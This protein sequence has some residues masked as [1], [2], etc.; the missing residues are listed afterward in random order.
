MV[1]AI[2]PDAKIE[3][4]GIRPGEKIHETLIATEEARHTV[5]LR[6]RYVILPENPSWGPKG[7]LLGDPVP[8][9]GGAALPGVSGQQLLVAS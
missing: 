2:A 8:E 3:I 5:S 6:D 9:E 1:R 4:T 7:K